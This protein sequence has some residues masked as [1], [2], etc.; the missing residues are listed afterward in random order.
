MGSLPE[1]SMLGSVMAITKVVD[2][3]EI[4]NNDMH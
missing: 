2:T 3:V 1:R 4:P